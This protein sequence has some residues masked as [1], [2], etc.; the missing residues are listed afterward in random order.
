M[1]PRCRVRYAIHAGS[2]IRRRVAG[3]SPALGDVDARDSR[4]EGIAPIPATPCFRGIHMR[5]IAVMQIGESDES[6][7]ACAA[8]AVHASA[9]KPP[10]DRDAAP[11]IGKKNPG[12]SRGRRV[13]I[14]VAVRRT[15]A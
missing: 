7:S 8:F 13:L 12:R 10:I 1:P 3:R 11:G 5:V 6:E 4:L 9:R 14:G 2:R 15:D